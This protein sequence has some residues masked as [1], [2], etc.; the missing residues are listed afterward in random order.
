M[1]VR[2]N[3][4]ALVASTTDVRPQER[5]KRSVF[6]TW[7]RNVQWVL[8]VGSNG[9]MRRRGVLITKPLGNGDCGCEVIVRYFIKRCSEFPR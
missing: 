9:V 7:A 5:I 4:D 3:S 6:Q 2:M 1:R 8:S